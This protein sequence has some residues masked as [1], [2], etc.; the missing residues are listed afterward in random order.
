MRSSQFLIRSL[1]IVLGI[2]LLFAFGPSAERRGYRIGELD[3][4][5]MYVAGTAWRSGHNPYD[6]RDFRSVA[7][8]AIP[9]AAGRVGPALIDCSFAYAPTSA[10]MAMAMAALSFDRARVAFLALNVVSLAVVSIFLVCR[11]SGDPDYQ[12]GNL[13][14]AVLPALMLL[15]TI[16]APPAAY[17]IQWGQTTLLALALLCAS[18]WCSDRARPIA[19]GILAAFASFKPSASVFVI[20]ALLLEGNIRTIISMIIALFAMAWVPLVREGPAT[21]MTD[22]LG[23][24]RLYQSF[25]QNSPGTGNVV[26]LG[27]LLSSVGWTA[28]ASPLIGLMLFLWAVFRR[29]YYTSTEHFSILLVLAL[30]CTSAH[31]YDWIIAYPLLLTILGAA[32]HSHAGLAGSIALIAVQTLPIS[33]VHTWIGPETVWR[34]REMT[35]MLTCLGVMV[36]SELRVWRK[37]DRST[38]PPQ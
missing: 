8:A 22:W 16:S 11:E 37:G 5:Y 24:V 23:S 1:A 2:V 4:S 12:R 6:F 27:P 14:K 28:G 33:F 20:G 32:S 17:N 29:R 21:L 18:R 15:L 13:V 30:L 10:G 7:S 19:C 35:L 3:F 31:G 34:F 26:G 36:S 25:P 38:V 9:T